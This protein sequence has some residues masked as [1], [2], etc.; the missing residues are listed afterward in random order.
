LCALGDSSQGLTFTNTATK[1]PIGHLTI[2]HLRWVQ[3][4]YQKPCWA[5]HPKPYADF[6]EW[7]QGEEREVQEM[8]KKQIR[9]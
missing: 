9:V 8:R 1:A 3:D 5:H 6:V 2:C 7:K 4:F